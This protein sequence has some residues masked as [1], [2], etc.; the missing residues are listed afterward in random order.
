VSVKCNSEFEALYPG[1]R[2]SRV[3][4]NTNKGSFK[5]TVYLPRGEPE[6]PFS[7]DDLLSKF[8]RLN[9]KFDEDTLGIIKKMDSYRA[10]DLMNILLN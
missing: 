9:P 8:Q 2:P 6:K 10:R 4:I 1:K 5:H 7:W 3:I